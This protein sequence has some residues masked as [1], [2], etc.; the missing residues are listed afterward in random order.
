[1]GYLTLE[2]SLFL[3]NSKVNIL[4]RWKKMW[5]EKNMNVMNAYYDDTQQ[6]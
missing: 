2:R 6:G 3:H 4:G 5:G 1:M